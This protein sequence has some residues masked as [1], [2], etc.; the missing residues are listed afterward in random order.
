MTTALG[1]FEKRVA[2]FGMIRPE[3][4]GH[5]ATRRGLSRTESSGLL[6]RRTGGSMVSE[7]DSGMGVPC[8]D[9]PTW[10]RSGYWLG[11]LR[12][13]CDVVATA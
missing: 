12:N 4:A 13:R 2:I 5:D 6:T 8:A 1:R 3:N 7:V 10:D 11:V 9:F